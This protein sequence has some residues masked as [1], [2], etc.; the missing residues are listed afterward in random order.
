[1]QNDTPER[2]SRRS[3]AEYV[4]AIMRSEHARRTAV[5]PPAPSRRSSRGPLLTLI[6]I[7][8]GLTAWNVSTYARNQ[9][10][11]TAEQE[12]SAAR[13]HVYLTAVAVDEHRN[14]TGTLPVNLT[15]IGLGDDGIEYSLAGQGYIL[16][17]ATA[18][19][20][21]SY[22]AGEDLQPFADEWNNF[23]ALAP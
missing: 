2:D 1:M 21:V 7:L 15:E 18:A 10:P 6:P 19:G 13:F 9:Q 5:E 20:P 4:E 12:Q 22:R 23:R 17:A 11:F 14:E 3:A 8:L 16:T